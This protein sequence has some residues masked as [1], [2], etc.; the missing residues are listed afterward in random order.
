MPQVGILYTCQRGDWVCTAWTNVSNA[1]WE[2]KNKTRYT[3]KYIYK[4]KASH[5]MTRVTLS[6]QWVVVEVVSLLLLHNKP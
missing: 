2:K 4:W 1:E 3:V 6:E 5:T